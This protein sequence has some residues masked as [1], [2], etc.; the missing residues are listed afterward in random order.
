VTIDQILVTIAGMLAV[1]GVAWFFWG[2]R[3]AGVQAAL[4]SSGAQEA[5]SSSRVPTPPT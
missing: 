4:T 1:A 2:P 5:T 3:R